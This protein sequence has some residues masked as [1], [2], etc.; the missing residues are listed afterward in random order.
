VNILNGLDSALALLAALDT[1]IATLGISANASPTTALDTVE[2][3]TRERRFAALLARIGVAI[4]AETHFELIRAEAGFHV[5]PRFART[6]I[7]DIH[8]PRIT[9][10]S[11]IDLCVATRSFRER[12]GIFAPTV[13]AEE[14]RR[15]GI[16]RRVHIALLRLISHSVAAGTALARV[17]EG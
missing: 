11:G 15:T 14:P 3:I 4:T 13:L 16:G 7:N 12:P 8:Y 9:R 5:T 10:F 17:A 2:T 1:T 6:R